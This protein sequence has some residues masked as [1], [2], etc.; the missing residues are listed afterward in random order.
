MPSLKAKASFHDYSLT[1]MKKIKVLLAEDDPIYIRGMKAY[2]KNLGY[3][4]AA[5]TTRAEEVLNLVAATGPDL[6]I[7]D[8]Q[9]DGQQTGIE[10]AKML[11][12]L[13][14][15]PIIFIT[16]L[17]DDAVFKQAMDTNPYAYL[18]KPFDQEN[19]KS[20]IEL[21]VHK[22]YQFHVGAFGEF[23]R[24]QEAGA[25]SENLLF[26]R[27]GGQLTKISIAEICCIEVQDK[28]V[29]VHLENE[30]LQVRHALKDFKNQLPEKQFFQIHR[31]FIINL[32]KIKQIDPT[33]QQVTIGNKIIPISKNF[34]KEF[35]EALPTL[36]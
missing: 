4:L 23:L 7:L 13:R 27:T 32:S 29:L 12:Q 24:K 3:E 17:R 31:S 15:L 25:S 11:N 26:L 33:A 16:A 21:A 5:H 18:C 34:R 10:T 2:L 8:I 36:K 1:T 9:L 30:T 35:L 20:A 14:P 28:E 6:V 22:F 19:L